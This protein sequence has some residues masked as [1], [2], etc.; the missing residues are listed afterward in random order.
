MTSGFMTRKSTLDAM[1]SMHMYSMY[2][3]HVCEGAGD[4]YDCEDG[5]SS[6]SDGFILFE[7]SL[8]F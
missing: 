1:Y 3:I 7:G 8:T 6:G 5:R 4:R 2:R